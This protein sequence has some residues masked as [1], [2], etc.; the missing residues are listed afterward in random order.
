MA[1]MKFK[2]TIQPYQTDAVDSIVKVFA[3]QPYQDRVSYRR[4]TGSQKVERNLFNYKLSDEDLFMGFAQTTISGSH[5]AFQSIWA[6]VR[7]MW[8]WKPE[9]ERLT[10]T[11]RPCSS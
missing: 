9:P 5:Q 2:F 6:A 10:F 11:S 4:D 7:W 8:R 1:D 3:G